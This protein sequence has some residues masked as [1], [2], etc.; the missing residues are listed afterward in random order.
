MQAW[1]W[2]LELTLI[3]MTNHNLNFTLNDPHHFPRGVFTHNADLTLSK[4]TTALC[5]L[6]VERMKV[7]GYTLFWFKT[8]IPLC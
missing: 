7:A 6:L 3:L 2:T 4:W 5:Q 1:K 8:I